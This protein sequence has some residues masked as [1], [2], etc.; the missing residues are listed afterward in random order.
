[1]YL[2]ISPLLALRDVHSASRVALTVTH[3]AKEKTLSDIDAQLLTL[4]AKI[5]SL[6]QHKQGIKKGAVSL[7]EPVEP[8]HYNTDL[9]LP[10]PPPSAELVDLVR[11]T[12]PYATLGS[13]F[14]GSVNLSPALYL[15]PS[16]G[17]QMPDMS[18]IDSILFPS[19]TAPH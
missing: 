6:T 18:D 10:P 2:W 17:G 11:N 13:S 9:R 5:K 1:M 19:S 7:P 4:R 3:K 12:L 8:M 16:F 14:N 15:P